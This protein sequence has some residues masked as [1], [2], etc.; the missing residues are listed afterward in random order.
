MWLLHFLPDSFLEYVVNIVLLAGLIGTVLFCFVINRILRWFPAL[1]PYYRALQITSVVVLLAGVYFKGGYST[2][3]EWRE[4]V[5]E[6]EKKV[7]AA[8]EK[9][10]KENVKIVEKVIKK[11]EY[12]KLKGKETISYIDREVTKYDSSCVIPNEFVKAHNQAAE[13]GGAKK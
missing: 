2:E 12:I 6:V 10:K 9:S 7:A 5:A 8:E 11:T 13:I 1:S 3:M 4:R